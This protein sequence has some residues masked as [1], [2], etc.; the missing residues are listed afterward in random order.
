MNFATFTSN[1]AKQ[2]FKTIL[3]QSTSQ[4]KLIFLLSFTK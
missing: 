2:V 3:I 4:N 1:D